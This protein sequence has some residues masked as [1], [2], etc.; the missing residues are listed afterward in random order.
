ML[1]LAEREPE[2]NLLGLSP[3]EIDQVCAQEALPSLKIS[4]AVLITAA[5]SG[6]AGIGLMFTKRK[7]LGAGM[8]AGG[9]VG[10]FG[11]RAFASSAATS[12]QTCRIRFIASQPKAA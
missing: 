4:T 11:A 7:G 2:A 1:H 6:V 9:V 10:W 8:V 3:Q 12:F 5:I